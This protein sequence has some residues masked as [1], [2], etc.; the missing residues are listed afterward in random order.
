MATDPNALK[1]TYEHYV[2]FP[3]DGKRHEI[4]DGEHFVNPAPSTRH[5]YALHELHAQLREQIQK[6]ELGI[7][8]AAPVDVQL[9]EFT[10]LQPDLVVI[11]NDRR[12]I[13]TDPKIDGAPS[14]VVEVTSPNSPKFDRTTKK[15]AYQL[16]GIPEYLIVDPIARTVEQFALNDGEY[17]ILPHNRETVAL[18][19]VDNVKVVVN[20]L[21]FAG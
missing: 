13:V 7:I 20:K 3:S 19:I 2:H 15:H 17:E 9:S 12:K 6:P 8:F 14:L 16:A 1:Y 18:T 4:V 11:L 10:V 21:W 5:Q